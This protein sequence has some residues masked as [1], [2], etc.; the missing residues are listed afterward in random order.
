MFY[1]IRFSTLPSQHHLISLLS[2]HKRTKSARTGAATGDFSSF[3]CVSCTAEAQDK[4]VITETRK[5]EKPLKKCSALLY[6]KV[7]WPTVWKLANEM[8]DKS[9]NCAIVC[10]S[11]D[12]D[13]FPPYFSLQLTDHHFFS[14]SDEEQTRQIQPDLDFS[15]HLN[16]ENKLYFL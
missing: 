2:Y 7:I 9:H 12:K 5:G 16:T 11:W 13:L 4:F 8:S 6:V 1:R 3:C 15:F 10:G 14:L